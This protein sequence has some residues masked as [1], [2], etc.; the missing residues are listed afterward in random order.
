MLDIIACISTM[1]TGNINSFDRLK[2][3]VKRTVHRWLQS[4]TKTIMQRIGS[5]LSTL[6]GNCLILK[7]IKS[8][9]LNLRDSVLEETV[10]FWLVN[11]F[12]NDILL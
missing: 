2:L 4:F 12:A 7:K 8:N 1:A 11:C 9:F 3:A 5:T 6:S 10:Y